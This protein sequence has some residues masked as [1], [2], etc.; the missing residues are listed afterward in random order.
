[1]FILAVDHVHEW[2]GLLLEE[3]CGLMVFACR[4]QKSWGKHADSLIDA[5]RS[6]GF[7]MHCTV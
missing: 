1:M 6:Q 2:R 5:G 4:V 7:A 3:F